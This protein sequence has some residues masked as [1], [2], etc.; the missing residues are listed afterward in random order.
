MACTCGNCPDC[1]TFPEDDSFRAGVKHAVE[2]I[3]A[4]QQ[5]HVEYLKKVGYV[6]TAQRLEKAQEAP[7]DTHDG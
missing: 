3:R 2:T 5:P 4:A 1:D 7:T 6:F